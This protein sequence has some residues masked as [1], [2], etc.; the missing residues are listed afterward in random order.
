[1]TSFSPIRYFD[2]QTQNLKDKQTEMRSLTDMLAMK[3][4]ERKEKKIGEMH[5][6]EAKKKRKE[7][8]TGGEEVER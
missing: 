3:R 6:L 2:R 1:M 8:E 7:I 5:T 4:K